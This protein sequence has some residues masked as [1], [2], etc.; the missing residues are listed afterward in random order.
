MDQKPL[1]SIIVPCYNYAHF[2]DKTI[3]NIREQELESWEC[4][5]IDDGSTDDTSNICKAWL[6]KDARFIYIYKQNGGLSS[7]RNEGL[8][9]AKGKYIQFLDADDLIHSSKLLHQTQILKDSQEF[10]I[11]YSSFVF[12][13]EKLEKKE[14]TSHYV[15]PKHK[16]MYFALVRE[17]EQGFMI[18]IHCYLFP[19]EIFQ[20]IGEFNIYLPTH[21]DL[22]IHL[23]IAIQEPKYIHQIEQYAIYRIHGNSMSRNYT[24][25][26]RGYIMV[27]LSAFRDSSTSWNQKTALLARIGNEITQSFV[28]LVRGRKISFI[29]SIA[30]DKA[31]LIISVGILLL[32]F[33]LIKK[34]IATLNPS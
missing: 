11:I 25:M 21:E 8:K 7:A 19:K 24:K 4:L 10:A 2:L 32:P 3:E 15:T 28:H 33:F 9:H 34:I 17:W 29:E 12:L 30:F 27:L 22:D 18:P 23:K 16:S 13:N 5:L 14:P 1:V 31:P 26:Q 20:K 6:Q